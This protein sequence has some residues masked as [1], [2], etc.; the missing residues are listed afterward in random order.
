M[1]LISKQLLGVLRSLDEGVAGL[2]LLALGDLEVG[3][4]RDVVGLL[5]AVVRDDRHP[6]ALVVLLDA[7]DAR[8]AGEDRRALR[9][10]RLEQLDDAGEAVGDVL[11]DDAT[12]VEGPHREL[13][14]GLADRLRGDDA[15]RLAELDQPPGGERLAVTERA[16]T[17][18]VDSQVSTERT[19]IRSIDGSACMRSMSASL[20]HRPDGEGRPVLER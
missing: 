18:W 15:D 2:D 12:G 16:Q 4:R 11:T 7:N 1:P 6:A 19:R 5:V 14:A 9:G 17:P 8:G 13:G 3:T 20:E 10:A